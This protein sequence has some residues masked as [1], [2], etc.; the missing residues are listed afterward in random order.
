LGV[1]MAA[2]SYQN[3]GMGLAA[4]GGALVAMS[5]LPGSLNPVAGAPSSIMMVGGAA[6]GALGA[7]MACMQG[8]ITSQI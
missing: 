6:L 2:M 1:D 4:A 7:G 3:V 8:N 5:I